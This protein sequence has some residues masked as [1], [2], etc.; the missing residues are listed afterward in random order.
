MV[1]NPTNDFV[2]IS[3]HVAGGITDAEMPGLDFVIAALG[4]AGILNLSTASVA[5]S[6]NQATTAWLQLTAPSYTAEGVFKL[7]NGSAYVNATMSLLLEMLAAAEKAAGSAIAISSLLDTLGITI[8]DIIV[9]GA[10]SWQALAPGVNGYVFTSNGSGNLPTWSALPAPPVVVTSF[11]TRTGAVTLNAGDITGAGGALI[12]SPTFTGDP[13]APTPAIGDNDTSIATTAF[14][15]TAINGL[16]TIYMRWVPY[17][18]PPQSFL[19][20]DMTRDGDWTMVANKNT[21]DRPAPQASGAEEDLLPAW[22]PT[23]SNANASYVVYNEWTLSQSGWI[24]QYGTDVLS[25]NINASHVI[26]LRVN[27]VIKDTFTATPTSAGIYWHDITPLLVVSGAVLRVTVQVNQPP[28]NLYWHQQTGLFATAPIYCSLAVG[29]KDGAAAGTTAYGCH[30]LFTPGVASPDW[31]V[32][33]Y[34]GAAAGGSGPPPPSPATNPPLMDGTAAVGTSLAYAREDHV[35]PSDTS[36]APLASPALTGIPTGPT[37]T[38]GTN[39]TQLA[40]TAF[41]LANA[42]SVAPSN[43]NPLM[44]GTAASG[45]S[46]LYSRGD[47][48]HPSDTSRVA[49]A[50]DTM[51]GN[52]TIATAANPSLILN[53]PAG[54]FTN[55]ILGDTAGN[56]RWSIQLG[57]NTTESGSNVGSD[58]SI[59]RYSDAGAILGS[60]LVINR[61]TGNATFAQSLTVSGNFTVAGAIS[62]ASVASASSATVGTYYFGQSG[63][64]YLTYDA[65][66]FRFVSGSVIADSFQTTSGYSILNDNGLQNIAGSAQFGIYAAGGY[67][68]TSYGGGWTW[69]WNPGNGDL[70]WLHGGSSMW[71]MRAGDSLT[72]NNLAPVGGNGAYVNISDRDVKDNIEDWDRGLDTVLALKPVRFTRRDMTRDT[73]ETRAAVPQ[74]PKLKYVPEIGFI[75]QDVRRVIPEAVRAVGLPTDDPGRAEPTLGMQDTPVIAAL[76]NAVKEL[77]DRIAKLESML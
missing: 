51:T 18:G 23:T 7:W 5:P 42:S 1:Y 54:A 33:A 63:T 74:A 31:D 27:G 57:N 38:V 35:H 56:T 53:K 30:L 8:G 22:V 50:G 20:Q 62:G 28:N 44:D 24:D 14:V 2:S 77:S 52:L 55:Y 47:H 64:K 21:S 73:P 49:K 40:T 60:P 69:E 26:T 4:R 75:A 66:N 61:S 37:A 58:F 29:S 59:D 13:K 34:G 65:T 25:Q 39:T 76:V 43:V 72:Y 68:Q 32:V 36:R 6:A 12:A 48:V 19:S 71:I 70:V 11:N 17:T 10:S 45:V 16:S 46:A 67:Y 41:V 3:R 9:R 15:S